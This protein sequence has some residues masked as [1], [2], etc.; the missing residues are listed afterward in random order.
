MEA[1]R[2]SSHRSWHNRKFSV[3]PLQPKL[4]S[5]SLRRELGLCFDA[6]TQDR[7]Y[8]LTVDDSDGDIAQSRFEDAYGIFNPAAQFHLFGPQSQAAALGQVGNAEVH[9]RSC[10]LFEFRGN[11]ELLASGV[12]Q[13]LQVADDGF[14]ERIH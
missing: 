13:H 2:H 7:I 8:I 6:K 4:K 12:K 9:N 11:E 10:R 5:N 1:V 3:V 14:L